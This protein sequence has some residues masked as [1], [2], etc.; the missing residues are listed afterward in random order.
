MDLQASGIIGHDFGML[1]IHQASTAQRRTAQLKARGSSAGDRFEDEA[2]RISRRIMLM[3]RP[4][5]S[6]GSAVSAKDADMHLDRGLSAS[7]SDASRHQPLPQTLRGFF[8]PRF[9]YDLGRVRIHCD[10]EAARSADALDASAFTSGRDISFAEG[11]YRPDSNEGKRLLA[12]ELVHVVQQGGAIPLGRH[13]SV[14]SIS[15]P[16]V[17]REAAPAPA[18][19]T[20]PLRIEASSA[21]ALRARVN[22]VV[23]AHFRLTGPS[24][25]RGRVSFVTP[26]EFASR[27]PASEMEEILLNL[28]FDPPT[29]SRIRDIL[30]YYHMEDILMGERPASRLP[31]R[32]EE[33]R[34]F[35]GERLR[36]GFFE[37]REVGPRETVRRTITP[38][39][40]LAENASGVTT[41]QPARG[42]R[43][44]I[45]QT[46]SEVGTLVHEAVHFYAHPNFRVQVNR[47]AGTR[48]F[49]DLQL[50]E[51]L[52]EGMTELFA[53]EV[54]HANEAE[55]G[56]LG[57]RAYESYIPVA[58]RIVE[59]TGWD[60]ARQ[61]YFQGNTAAINRLFRAIDAV[62][63]AWPLR[64]PSE[65][66]P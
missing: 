21:D 6:Q 15:P 31:S 47:R 25:T 57:H 41:S 37:Y 45:V 44:V 58:Y 48:F 10:S 2:N 27:F 4:L 13:Q 18:P 46:S 39:E 28:F 32:L 12:H 63:R 11:M 36:E 1:G 14:S 66:F 29:G 59:T 7:G 19:R 56:P 30:R 43:R 8:E 23:R 5:I 55:F 40:L 9:G 22:V 61:A 62:E 42:A 51:V 50:T 60:L 52:L 65:F 54:M 33:L 20:T 35:I 3:D 49:R 53:R 24:L 26:E 16:I 17:Q 64:I 38:G 34:R